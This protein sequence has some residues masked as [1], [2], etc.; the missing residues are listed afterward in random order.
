M[1]AAA[2]VKNI[3]KSFSVKDLTT[4]VDARDI[5][6][7]DYK[8]AT[9]M[10]A[11]LTRIEAEGIQQ[12][13]CNLKFAALK[14]VCE[15]MDVALGDRN[16]PTRPVFQKRLA[17]RMNE[18]GLAK[19]L[20]STQLPQVITTI[21]EAAG[22]F[23]IKDAS[24]ED[25]V[26]QTVLA[27]QFQ[28]ASNFFFYFETPFLR[29][30]M[31]AAGLDYNTGS[32][33]RLIQALVSHDNAVTEREPAEEITYSSK[34]LSLKAKNNLSYHDINEWYTLAELV[35][36]CEK[37]GVRTSGTKREV[38]KRVMAYLG[39][40]TE[41]TLKENSKP[42]KTKKEVVYK[43]FNSRNNVPRKAKKAK[44]DTEDAEEDVQEEEVEVEKKRKTKK[45]KPVDL[46]Q[47]MEVA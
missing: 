37:K 5:L 35:D 23:P 21:L 43:S 38:V 12:V 40:D 19:F 15:Q 28:G 18:E 16:K 2:S 24:I 7:Q 44:K 32:K 8:R 31:D 34:K 4:I 9:L 33:A 41:N 46:P 29:D 6:T 22:E 26:N 20:N 3:L 42:K 14:F 45:V 11:I 27:I 39:G 30:L 13:T 17:E 36:W 1:T 47:E 10:S 25:L